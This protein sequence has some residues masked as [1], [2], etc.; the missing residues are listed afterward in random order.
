MMRAGDIVE[1]RSIPQSRLNVLFR[2]NV[3][4]NFQSVDNSALEVAVG[5]ALVSGGFHFVH[6]LEGDAA[7]RLGLRNRNG[8]TV[9]LHEDIHGAGGFAFFGQLG[10]LEIIGNDHA[11]A[12]R[13]ESFE[14]SGITGIR[15]LLLTFRIPV[16][17]FLFRSLGGFS[18]GRE[19]GQQRQGTGPAAW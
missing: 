16:D 10:L 19:P 8:G 13:T 14:F 18:K 15:K 7:G 3:D 4:Q 12:V 9:G 1:K 6:G 11:D 5:V 2:D 17:H